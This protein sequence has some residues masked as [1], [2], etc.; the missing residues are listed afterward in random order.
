MPT[1]VNRNS[2][3]PTVLTAFALPSLPTHLPGDMLVIILMGKSNNIT[4]PTINNGWNSINRV[5]GGGGV[6]GVDTGPMFATAFWKIA[7]ASETAPTIT[8]GATAPTTWSWIGFSARPSPGKRWKT[9]GSFPQFTSASDADVASPLTGVGTAWNPPQPRAED[10]ILFAGAAVPSDVSTALASNTVSVAPWNM[11]TSVVNYLENPTGSDMA[12]ASLVQHTMT[13]GASTGP[14]SAS[15]TFTGGTN[16]SGLIAFVLVEDEV[17]P[18]VPQ[19][20]WGTP[21]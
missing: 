18:F 11:G 15:V 3:S 17:R 12:M 14:P 4:Q 10:C 19:S 6:E 5:F 16:H 8:P 7:G 9:T 21:I 2:G 20:G 13:G 1:Y